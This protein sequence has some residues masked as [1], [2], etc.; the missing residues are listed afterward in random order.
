MRLYR[1]ADRAP[2]REPRTASTAA[3]CF[4]ISTEHVGDDRGDQAEGKNPGQS[5]HQKVDH[6]GL[7]SRAGFVNWRQIPTETPMGVR[8]SAVAEI[9]HN[10]SGAL[11]PVKP[12]EP[13][14]AREKVP[15][16]TAET[17]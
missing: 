12:L 11:A 2:P 3:A 14:D 5:C 7:R 1:R 17:R 13:H 15:T 9:C 16:T 8:R 4:M 10:Q 6:S